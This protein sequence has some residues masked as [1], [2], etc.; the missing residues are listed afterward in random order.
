MAH[1]ETDYTRTTAITLMAANVEFDLPVILIDRFDSANFLWATNGLPVDYDALME[2]GAAYEGDAGMA[3]RTSL[4]A[5][6]AGEF[7]EVTRYAYNTP[8]RKMSFSALF[9]I[10]QD[11]AFV[12]ELFFYVRG[13]YLNTDYITGFRYRAAD[14]AWDYFNAAGGWTEFLTGIE[15]HSGAWNRVYFETDL[16]NTQYIAF[17]TADTR[18]GLVGTPIL[19]AAPGIERM[20]ALTRLTNNAVGTRADASIDNVIIKELGE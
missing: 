2:A 11:E 7:V 1:G 8:R 4:A 10:N 19:T 15:Q 18:I 9:R 13:R 14:Q 16:Q 20:Y 12:R 17:E 6:A 3:L 5:A